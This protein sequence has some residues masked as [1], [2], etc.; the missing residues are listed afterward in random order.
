MAFID[1]NLMADKMDELSAK[2]HPMLSQAGLAASV[3]AT[4]L[5]G[6][7]LAALVDDAKVDR[8]ERRKLRAL[9]L[10]LGLLGSDIDDFIQTVQ[11]LKTSGEQNDFIN[12]LKRTIQGYPL[13]ESFMAD[14]QE[15]LKKEGEIPESSRKFLDFI[16]AQLLGEP[17]WEQALKDR[18][19][20]RKRKA[21][22]ERR[23]REQEA[24]RRR[25]AEEA[26]RRAEAKR[27]AERK[28]NEIREQ[29]KKKQAEYD[30]LEETVKLVARVDQNEA[31]KLIRER[32]KVKREIDALK[33]KIGEDRPSVGGL[34]S[35]LFQSLNDL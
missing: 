20:E 6:C 1:E 9:G 11:E 18:K 7:V 17:D 31:L 2:P 13:V 12:E 19:A 5:Q 8:A 27:E 16:G 32:D 25:Q 29:I 26:R 30:D 15:I 34:F 22:A 24:E 10:S 14:F 35:S 33:K 21:D 4:Y 23:R 28:K 3:K